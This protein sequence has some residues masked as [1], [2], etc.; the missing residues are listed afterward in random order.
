[1]KTLEEYKGVNLCDL[2]FGNSY[3]DIMPKIRNKREID[4][5]GFIKILEV[6]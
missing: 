3:L 2:E 5:L 1:M 6:H 4:K